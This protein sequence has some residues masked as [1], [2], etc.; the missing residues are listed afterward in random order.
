MRLCREISSHTSSSFAGGDEVSELP[1]PQ[2]P[3]FPR[4][5]RSS[6]YLFF[7]TFLPPLLTK[8]LSEPAKL[9]SELAKMVLLLRQASSS[10][11]SASHVPLSQILPLFAFGAAV[12][13]RNSTKRG[14]GSTKN[15]RNSPG[16][17][18]GVKRSG[19]E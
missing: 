12:Q 11:A 17:R 19:G 14:G 1:A 5:D 13:V 9:P 8:S 16:K 15:N 2:A 3:Y 18:L 7:F 6:D 10:L 4:G